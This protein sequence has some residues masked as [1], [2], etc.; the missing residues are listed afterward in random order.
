M[1]EVYS[2]QWGV[3]ADEGQSIVAAIIDAATAMKTKK[4]V[5]SESSHSDMLTS[6]I[7]ALEECDSDTE[8][9]VRRTQELGG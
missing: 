4:L 9:H 6:L 5:D 1:M 8:Q 2:M 3:A 7:R